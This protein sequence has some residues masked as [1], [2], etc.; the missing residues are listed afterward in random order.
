MK[1]E[2]NTLIFSGGGVKGIAY[3]GV[4]KYLDEICK[5]RYI[6]EQSDNFNDEQCEIPKINIKT[7]C[8]VSIGSI[9]GLL[10]VLGYTFDDLIEE[11]NELDLPQLKN[12]KIKNIFT[13]YG[14]DKGLKVSNWIESLILKKGYSKKITFKQL[15]NIKGIN[16]QVLASNVNK[17]TYTIFDTINT[18][19]LKIKDAIRMSISI[20]FL[21]TIKEYNNDIH[22]DGAL[23]NN[24]PIK[25]FKDNLDNVLGFKLMSNGELE[26]HNINVKIDC[27]E[28]YIYNIMKCF[29]VQK[30]KET[31][32][33]Y[34]YKD[35][36]I[37]I[38]AEDV[39]H[40]LNFE[41]T[42][43][44]KDNLINI[45]YESTRKYFELK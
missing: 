1:K 12:F 7:V 16:L 4:L 25:L 26:S 41:L 39:T 14:F 30:E 40:I 42:L 23:I 13:E 24:Y 8:G 3:I 15:Y 6:V 44:E 32:L 37:C 9:I 22:V 38:E 29:I 43:D 21:F 20:P 18:P 45:G 34:I 19:D 10:Y 27:L 5:K 17:Y 28:D 11:L 2:I 36:T 33:S 31:T 35:H